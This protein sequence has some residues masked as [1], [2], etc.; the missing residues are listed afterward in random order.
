MPKA[1]QAQFT[2]L[3]PSYDRR[4]YLFVRVAE[5]SDQINDPDLTGPLLQVNDISK[6]LVWLCSKQTDKHK[7][8][9]SPIINGNNLFLKAATTI[10]TLEIFTNQLWK[11][12]FLFLFLAIPWLTV[13]V[14]LVQNCLRFPTRTVWFVFLPFC[15]PR[16]SSVESRGTAS[17]KETTTVMQ[18]WNSYRREWKRML[19]ES[20]KNRF[21]KINT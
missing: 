10:L 13:K 8:K 19:T 3:P 11:I 17:E 14:L 18:V 5:H 4:W 15:H 16:R 2:F 21:L 6:H 9:S 1:S 7:R 12:K 20:K